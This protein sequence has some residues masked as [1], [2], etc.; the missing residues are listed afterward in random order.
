MITAHGTKYMLKV[1][2][3]AYCA[4]IKKD[5]SVGLPETGNHFWMAL[6]LYTMQT[7][8]GKLSQ[9]QVKLTANPGSG[10]GEDVC[11]D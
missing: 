10:C 11:M 6:A 4:S 7:V 1:K 8:P 5:G 2:F 3:K 9:S